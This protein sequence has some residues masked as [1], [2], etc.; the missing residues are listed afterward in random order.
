MSF[1]QRGP[2]CEYTSELPFEAESYSVPLAGL[3]VGVDNTRYDV[4]ISPKAVAAIRQH[5][6]RQIAHHGEVKDLIAEQAMASAATPVWSSAKRLN[7]TPEPETPEF[8]RVLT[9]LFLGSLESA[10]AV[11]N[12]TTDVL[13][14]LAILKLLRAELGLQFA[15][16]LER[17]REKL[18]SAERSH[19]ASLHEFQERVSRLQIFKHAVLRKTGQ[20][21]F[22]TLREIEKE[23]LARTRRAYFGEL[24]EDSYKLFLNRLIMTKDGTDD[25]VNAEQYLL[26]GTYDADPDRCSYLNTLACELLREMDPALEESECEAT[27]NVPQNVEHWVG[28]ITDAGS[29]SK[30]QRLVL[31]KWTE[32]LERNGVLDYLVAGYEAAALLSR[33]APLIGAQQLKRAL[34][35]RTERKRVEALLEQHGKI[36]PDALVAAARRVEDC[37]G[38]D[39]SRIAARVLNDFVRY[40]RDLRRFE[41]LLAALEQ[42]NLIM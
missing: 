38:N 8:K 1:L 32:L 6:S 9:E 13:A 22:S 4:W 23:S 29:R 17:C 28:P 34:V 16:V 11:E 41:V 36:A 3:Q 15:V 19:S 7:K 42:V 37:R 2:L 30:V 12:I 40:H 21:I 14:R 5:I 20:E 27:L 24:A 18:K 35:S 31:E 25:A 10:R 26:L 39:R 33:Y